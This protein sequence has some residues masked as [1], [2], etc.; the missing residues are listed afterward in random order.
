LIC[1]AVG[2]NINSTNKTA[3]QSCSCQQSLS[4]PQLSAL[5]RCW[6]FRC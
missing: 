6:S 5:F 4:L 1:F 2:R 3:S